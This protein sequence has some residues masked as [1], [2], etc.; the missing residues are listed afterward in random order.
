MT[1]RLLILRP[2]SRE[3]RFSIYFK[4]IHKIKIRLLGRFHKIPSSLILILLNMFISRQHHAPW[5]KHLSIN[6][7][8]LHLSAWTRKSFYFTRWNVWY[9]IKLLRACDTNYN[10]TQNLAYVFPY[11]MSLLPPPNN[12]NNFI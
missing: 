7:S 2:F 11:K 3:Y 8:N 6:E 12:K 4:L 1:V 10:F 5:S 9:K